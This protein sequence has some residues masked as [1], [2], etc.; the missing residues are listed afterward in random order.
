MAKANKMGRKKKDNPYGFI[1]VPFTHTFDGFPVA[2]SALAYNIH[3]LISM[4]G[5]EKEH[6]I[7]ALES[8]KWMFTGKI[9]E[10]MLQ[11][12]KGRCK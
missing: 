8:A 5:A 6:A 4:S 10:E 3:A 7:S 11:Q 12:L 2:V 9:P 1:D